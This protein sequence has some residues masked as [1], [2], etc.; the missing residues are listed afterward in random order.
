MEDEGLMAMPAR[1]RTLSIACG[2]AVLFG[3]LLAL[4][5]MFLPWAEDYYPDWNVAGNPP[6]PGAPIFHV[7]PMSIFFHN[8]DVNQ[9]MGLACG[10]VFLAPP[11]ALVARGLLV[12]ATR[13]W[14]AMG[15]VVA[16][17]TGLA[18]AL[19][20]AWLY[21][22]PVLNDMGTWTRPDVG[23]AVVALGYGCALAARVAG[24]VLRLDG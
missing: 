9:G 5:G 12:C 1:V 24:G 3:G 18:V 20:A 21:T 19:L 2:A 10:V 7:S 15:V 8:P 11:L 14:R 13:R 4:V 6:V 16:A 17:C 22:H 23:L